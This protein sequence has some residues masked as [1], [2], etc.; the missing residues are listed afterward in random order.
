MVKTNK[1]LCKS[2]AMVENNPGTHTTLGPTFL[3]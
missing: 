1:D 3:G 2:K